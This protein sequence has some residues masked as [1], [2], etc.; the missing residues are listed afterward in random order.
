MIAYIL[1]CSCLRFVE[2]E[3][4]LLNAHEF[5]IH[6]GKTLI[7]DSQGCEHIFEFTLKLTVGVNNKNCNRDE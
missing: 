2:E 7:D 5:L 3:V 1:T 6:V 4:I